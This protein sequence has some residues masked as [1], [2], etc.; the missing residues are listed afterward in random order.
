MMT[1]LP[2]GAWQYAFL[3]IF[4]FA[5]A[6]VVC[7]TILSDL[8]GFSASMPETYHGQL[9]MV[10]FKLFALTMGFMLISGAFG[11]WAIQFSAETE[12]R[13]R[14]SEIVE[15]MDYLND[16][17][18]A[19]D[20]RGRIT[21]A[22]PSLKSLTTVAGP[23]KRPFVGEIFPCLSQADVELLLNMEGPNEIQR[24]THGSSGKRTLRFR[25]Q[26]AGG[27]V[28]V[29]VGDV[30]TVKIEE[31]RR[32]HIAHLQTIGRIA[33]GVTNDFNNIFT[34]ISGHASILSRLPPG[35]PETRGSLSA[36][37]KESERGA[38]L[39]G[40]L[41][42]FSR[43]SVVGRQCDNLGEHVR[44]ASELLGLGV[45]TGWKVEVKTEEG[46]PSVPLSGPQV[47]QVLLQLGLGAADEA[48]LPGVI[49]ITAGKPSDD[50][51]MNVGGN[52]AAVIVMSVSDVKSHPET[53]YK[54]V[55]PKV[56]GAGSEESGVIQSMVRSLI[57][58]ADGVLDTFSGA[59]NAK[60]FR[61]ILPYGSVEMTSGRAGI[62]NELQSYMAGWRVL[63]ARKARTHD[64]LEARLK[65]AGVKVEKVDSIVVALARIE[66]ESGFNAIVVEKEL[67]GGEAV[68]LIKALVKICRGTGIVVMC[69]DPD[70]ESKDLWGEVVFVSGRS[71][72]GRVMTSMIESRAL[73]ARR[74]RR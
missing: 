40:H 12:S 70:L 41:I 28:L 52:Y 47:E 63:L 20:S 60:I 56:V 44:K 51:L 25:S 11:L 31:Q 32:R 34:G 59:G 69:E 21:G 33:R 4:L 37:S 7:W 45:P 19:V 53:G 57:E 68:G 18:M 10:S 6:A 50:H 43:L 73:I 17:L 64:H 42:E 29:L 65:E 15:T 39:A 23:W 5:I 72:P 22:N 14:V 49:R 58:E 26:T 74:A 61:I 54:D 46:F 1:S 71:D 8:Y 66:D 2:R 13:R 38:A 35:S 27:I 30:T 67:M 48:S 3:L 36:I 24:D 55:E 62:S 16:G 9:N